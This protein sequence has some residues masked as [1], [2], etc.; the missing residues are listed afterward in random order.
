MVLL[1]KNEVSAA[2]SGWKA[3]EKAMVGRTVK[4]Y[5]TNCNEV[6]ICMPLL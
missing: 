3:K 2:K 1:H 5:L 4:L 6:Y